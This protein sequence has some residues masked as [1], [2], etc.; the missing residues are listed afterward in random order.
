MES[1]SLVVSDEILS[2]YPKENELV[3]ELVSCRELSEQLEESLGEKRFTVL[4][5]RAKGWNFREIAERLEELGYTNRQGK[6][7]SRQ[8]VKAILDETLKAVRKM[9]V[10]H[11]IQ[12]GKP[13]I[14]KGSEKKSKKE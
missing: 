8:A 6:Q 2:K 14:E 5:L 3:D 10:F 12:Q 1:I 7:I 4:S 13:K 11:N 9:R